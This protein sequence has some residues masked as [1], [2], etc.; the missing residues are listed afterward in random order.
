M[1]LLLAGLSASA[2]T[3]PPANPYPHSRWR[4]VPLTEVR[5][6]DGF[7]LERLR[8]VQEKTLPDLLDLAEE[9][10]KLDN[11]RLVAGRPTPSGRTQ[12][13]LFNAPDSDVYKLLEAAAYSL[14]LRPAPE[15]ARR[16]DALIDLIAAAQQPDGYLNTQYTLPFGHPASPPPENRHARTFGYGP[17]FRWR[18][19][20][21]EWP[22]GYS[23]LYCAGHLFEAAVAHYR[24]TGQRRLLDVALRLAEHIAA[25]FTPEKI[26][27]YAEHPEVELGLMQLYEVTGRARYLELADQLA[28]YVRFSRPP[29]LDRAANSRPLVEQ[30]AAIGH[31][32]RTAYLY[33]GATDVVRATG[34]ADLVGAL[35][36][37][38]ENVVSRKMYVHGGTGNGAPAEQHGH[39]YDLPLLATYSETCAAIA[40]AQWNH[41]LNLRTGQ[42]RYAD[43]VELESWNN[44]LAGVSL[45]GTEYFYANKLNLGTERR[46][47][48]HSGVR[49]RYLFCCPAK[50]PVFLAGLARWI[51]AVP[52]SPVSAREPALVVNQFVSS[53]VATTLAGR[54]LRLTQ[55]TELPAGGTTTF[56][57]EQGTGAAW[58][59]RVRLPAWARAEATGPIPHG[60][61]AYAV[62]ERPTVRVTLNRTALPAESGQPDA[63]GYLTLRRTW[64]AGDTFR[65]EFSLPVRRVHAAPVIVAQRGRVALMRGPLL[66]CL[67]GVDHAVDVQQLRLPPTAPLEARFAPALLGGVMTLVGTA[68]APDGQPTP[69]CAIPYFAWQNRGLHALATL[70]IED[71][72]QLTPEQPPASGPMNTNG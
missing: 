25:V 4:E 49:C 52:T 40:Q 27:D 65:V 45:A 31:A 35:D 5:L 13:R 48:Q 20:A 22:R 21:A 28:R 10:G 34:A 64:Q 42:A 1:S 18:S 19:L 72:D 16:I 70:L 7:W 36:R 58:A 12:L 14:A 51:Y 30:S 47:N 38:W 59:L 62:G 61:Y 9:Q 46:T 53:T 55:R 17:E 6:L 33:A 32:V 66:Y 23:Q 67:E 26:R 71:P 8:V 43:L 54:P 3:P 50:A 44:A 11:F 39:D 57:V 41:R 15:L 60:P 68:S 24:A 63:D 69:L 29:D 56:T 2:E 37:L